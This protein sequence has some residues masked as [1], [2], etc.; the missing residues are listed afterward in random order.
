MTGSNFDNA[1][2]TDIDTTSTIRFI[3]DERIYADA[4]D[5]YFGALLN[6]KTDWRFFPTKSY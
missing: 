5:V 1:K 3:S 6:D 2:A 4:I